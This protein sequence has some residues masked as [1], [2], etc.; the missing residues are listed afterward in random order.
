[1][2][3]R[4]LYTF[5]FLFT[6]E[7]RDLWKPWALWIFSVREEDPR[8]GIPIVVFTRR[9]QS[10]NP[11]VRSPHR[12]TRNTASRVQ[13]NPEAFGRIPSLSY[14]TF[15]SPISYHIQSLTCSEFNWTVQCLPPSK[16]Y[17]TIHYILF[18][19]LQTNALTK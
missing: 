12:Q 9:G 18:L 15:P 3:H 19:F 6:N 8:H 5:D 10:L 2:G 14:S 4:P 17:A 11:L 7:I 1:M 16:R 13:Y